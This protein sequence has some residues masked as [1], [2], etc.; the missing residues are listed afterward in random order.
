MKLLPLLLLCILCIPAYAALPP[1]PPI[2]RPVPLQSPKAASVP[3]T[4]PMVKASAFTIASTGGPLM[5]K[6]VLTYDINMN[7]CDTNDPNCITFDLVNIPAEQRAGYDM[8]IQFTHAIGSGQWTEAVWSGAGPEDRV[9]NVNWFRQKWQRPTGEFWRSVSTL[10]A[11]TGTT[12]ARSLSPAVRV[13]NSL[14]GI[15]KLTTRK[16]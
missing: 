7:G 8:S 13:N 16:K 2:P 3:K 6:P 10:A 14:P 5:L 11:P 4:T 15:I 9:S 1:V 12:A